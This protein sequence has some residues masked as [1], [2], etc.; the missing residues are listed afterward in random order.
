MIKVGDE[1]RRLGDLREAID[2][3]SCNLCMQC[4]GWEGVLLGGWGKVRL[5]SRIMVGW[6]RGWLL[7][8]ET[9]VGGARKRALQVFVILSMVDRKSNIYGFTYRRAAWWLHMCVCVEYNKNIVFLFFVCLC[10]DS[11]QSRIQLAYTSIHPSYTPSERNHHKTSFWFRRVFWG[12]HS[13]IPMI[14]NK[15]TQI[16]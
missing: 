7:Q 4:A 3:T 1:G 2:R 15:L 11:R 13:C 6:I 10:W 9:T 12:W 16:H 14:W 5:R 8:L